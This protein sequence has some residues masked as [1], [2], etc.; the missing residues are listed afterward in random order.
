MQQKNF[1][2]ITLTNDGYIEYT[3]NLVNS[4][5]D[6]NLE[7]SIKIYC[8]GKKSFKHFS[9]QA[10]NTVYLNS[11]I[12]NSKNIFQSWRSKNFNKLMFIKLSIIYENLKSSDQVLYC[13]GDIVFLK[14]PLEELKKENNKDI[15]A[16]FDF[17]P[18]KD[19]KTLC[20]GFMLVNSNQKTLNLFNPSNVPSELLDRHYYFDDQKYI[21]ENIS[22][23]N[24]KLLDIKEY[25]NGAYFYKNFQK[26]QP[27]II[28]FN[29][30][31]GNE[32]K[33]KMQ[34]MGFWSI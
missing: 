9:D 15:V 12:F 19:V 10:L 4:L 5:S 14:N 26:L 25:P 32:K 3:Q 20:A 6:I 29:Y 33:I 8:V 1:E 21:N 18:D 13:D 24:C 28:H 27:K 7:N 31:L 30:L 2:F 22:D 11:G 17:N 34:D 16:Q 23:L